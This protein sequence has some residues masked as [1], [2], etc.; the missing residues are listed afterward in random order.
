MTKKQFFG[1][2]GG[3]GATLT[4]SF[5]TFQTKADMERLLRPRPRRHDQERILSA[6][7]GSCVTSALRVETARISKLKRG[8]RDF[9]DRCGDG[10]TKKRF[11]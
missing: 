7:D 6:R 5:E 2:R 10:V 9:L 8:R 1:D 3:S 4:I 11:S